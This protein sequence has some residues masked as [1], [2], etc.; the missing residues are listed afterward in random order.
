MKLLENSVFGALSSSLSS[1]RNNV[2]ITGTIDS[3]SCKKTGNDKK[4]Y[5]YLN[6]D[7][8]RSPSDME[9]LSPPES[10]LQH[11]HQLGL[12]PT[13]PSRQLSCPDDNDADRISRKM[14]F[15]LLSTLN[16]AFPDYDFSQ[17]KSSEFSRE[18]NLSYV[19]DDVNTNLTTSLGEDFTNISVGLWTAIEEEIRLRECE[20]YSYNPDMESDPFVEEGCLWSFNYLFYNKHLKRIVFIKFHA[21]ALLTSPLTSQSEYVEDEDQFQM[22]W[23]VGGDEVF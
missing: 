19:I 20:I 12:T 3:Y 8:G 2:R 4:L 18:P 14:L 21:N 7:V 15:T 16:A 1:Q 10:Q 22:D 6:T 23:A 5:K 13:S 9:V 17:V 11:Q